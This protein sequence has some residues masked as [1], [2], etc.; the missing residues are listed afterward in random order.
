MRLRIIL[1]AL[2]MLLAIAGCSRTAP[3]SMP[4]LPIET[5]TPG[6][7]PTPL[8]EGKTVVVDGQLASLYPALPL[9]FGDGVSGRVITITVRPGDVVQAG[10]LLAVL[11]ETGLQR[12]VE[13]AQLALERA[14]AD[15]DLAL[16]QWEQDL[17]DA[18]QVL[19]D[20]K[21]ALAIARLQYSE[22]GLEEAR[23]ALDLARKAEKDREWEYN[24]ALRAWPP[25]PANVYYDAWQRAI[26][27][28][29]LAEMR[30]ADAEDAR[31]AGLLELQT[32]QAE[33]SKAERRLAALQ[34]GISPVYE[35]AIKEAEQKLTR[36]QDT[37]KR[38]RL[39]APWAAIVV[40]VDVAPQAIVG[41]GTSIVT[42]LN[43]EE[44]LRFVSTNLSE[45]H[46]ADVYPGQRAVVTLRSYPEQ[47][48]EGTVEA[49][50]PQ[51]G[52]GKVGEAE[53]RFT[54][55]VR[56]AEQPDNLRLL[57]GLTGRVEISAGPR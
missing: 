16:R 10:D 2:L 40:S 38:A 24:E 15:R 13:D 21:R 36:A 7:T 39:V 42:L 1:L 3:A 35:L 25:R 53:A 5:A 45:Q 55:R 30:L 17:A 11:D 50:V 46:V 14:I 51:V 20:T 52:E 37:L 22:T 57:P 19:T 6:P 54:V 41:A 9:A 43:V 56:L 34:G 23:T 28:R 8:H 44:G 12:A 31:S 27:E 33:V 48:L 49:V 26:R 4:I 18:W 47:P 32:R 29:E